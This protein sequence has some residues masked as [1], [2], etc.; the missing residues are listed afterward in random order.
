MGVHSVSAANLRALVA[1]APRETPDPVPANE[2]SAEGFPELGRA[3]PES[4]VRQEAKTASLEQP[5]KEPVRTD[6]AGTRLRVD[7]ETDR[8]VAQILDQKGEVITQ[9]PP[10]VLLKILART[11]EIQSMMFDQSV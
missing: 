6:K 2:A 4:E 8:I 5:Q 7:G 10:D 1:L 3:H 11:R 9:V